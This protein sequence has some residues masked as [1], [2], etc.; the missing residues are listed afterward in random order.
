MA[1]PGA[2]S[3]RSFTSRSGATLTFTAMGFGTAPLG[4]LYRPMSERESDETLEAAWEVGCR[5]FD[6][7]PLYGLGLSE[8]RLNRVLRG[9]RP[10]RPLLSTKVGRVLSV[11][12]PQER[13]GQGKFFDVPNRKE[14]YDYSYDGVMRAL[15][16]S[17]ERLGVDEIDILYCH[18]VDIFTHGSKEASDRR[19]REF[20]EGGYKAL[21][22]LR[23]GGVVKAIGAGI[24][25]WQV[26][27]TLAR[28]GD[29]DLFLLAGRYTL[30]EQDSLESFL[31]YCTEKHIGIVLGGPTIQ[32]SWPRGRVP[33][34]STITSRPP[35]R[36]SI[37]WPGSRRSARR[38]ASRWPRPRW[39]SRSPIPR[40]SAS[41]RAASV[42]RRS[43]ATRPI[44]GSPSRPRSGRT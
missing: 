7:A 32:A 29:F 5:Y 40:S 37:G 23:E 14:T 27:E 2:S 20:M 35:G 16:Q 4:N 30:L 1:Q 39:P 13:A 33:A 8:T 9:K 10:E 12:R 31:P 24:N 44:S 26:A 34:P 42:P 11:C 28:A 18:D 17:F 19:I 36:S 22:E 15:E 3:P 6:T 38:M 21:L 43:G 41:S 25:E